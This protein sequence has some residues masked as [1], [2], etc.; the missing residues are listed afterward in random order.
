MKIET[1]SKITWCPGCGNFGILNAVKN[2]ISEL[3]KEGMNENN[4]VIV[5]GIGCHG[6]IS[7]YLKLNSFNA[8]HGRV[9]PVLTGIKL[10]NKNLIPIGFSG[11]G[12]SY[13]EGIAHL[14]HGA[15]RNSDVTVI[16]HN[17]GVFG[18]TTGQTGPTSRKGWV[19]K[20]TPYGNPEEP[21]NPIGMMLEAGATFVARAFALKPDHLKNLI[22]EAVKH[23]GFSF[24]DVLQ[25][26][27]TYNNF[28]AEYNS[29][30]YEMNEIPKN[31]IEKC[32]ETTRIPIG[33]FR[34]IIKP[35]YEDTVVSLMKS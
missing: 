16:I 35:T 12:D 27:T 3:V 17:N 32:N 24:I 4:I 31:P 25:P 13:A 26:C 8:L 10:A 30:V 20:T 2:A 33:I 14:I 6:K 9:V 28:S 1:K 15:K 34:K 19:D 23:K 18:L 7:D 22:K 11:D 29:K 21:I 5:S